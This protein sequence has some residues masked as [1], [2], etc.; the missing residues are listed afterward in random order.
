MIK[1]RPIHIALLLLVLI[2]CSSLSSGTI[3]SKSDITNERKLVNFFTLGITHQVWHGII[4]D[5][6]VMNVTVS[7]KAS[8]L[9]T[10]AAIGQGSLWAF[11]CK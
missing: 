4:N 1:Y 10:V 6:K 3:Y 9:Q 11:K 2:C 5:F 7:C 8:L